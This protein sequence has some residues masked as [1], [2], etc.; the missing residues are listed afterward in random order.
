MSEEGEE[1]KLF[2]K[3]SFTEVTV[4]DISLQRYISLRPV[5][6][7]HTGGRHEHRRFGKAKVPIVERLINKLMSPGIVVRGKGLR[8]SGRASGKKIRATNIVKRAFDII[9]LKTGKNPLQV[10]IDAIINAGPREEDTRVVY[11]G[12]TYR[13]P[14][15][16][17]PQRRIDL[18]IRFIAEAA[19]RNTFSNL[20]TFE[21]AL[22]DEIIA[23]AEG[24]PDS[25]AIKKKEEKE[26]LARA[27]R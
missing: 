6:I 24:S 19:W 8:R 21:E 15:D 23:A 14:A 17:A 18:A 1:I 27:S 22:A 9:H 25:F 16:T 13:Q 11:G 20:K 7:P 5:Y 4:K 12:I 2:G 10:F 26:R 3:W